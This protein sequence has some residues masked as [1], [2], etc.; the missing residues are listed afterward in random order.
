MIDT[1]P[2]IRRLLSAL[3]DDQRI[4]VE[5]E[6]STLR[7]RRGGPSRVVTVAVALL[8]AAAAAFL[9]V[10]AFG[11]RTAVQPGEQSP[12]GT[13]ALSR[14]LDES[15]VNDDFQSVVFL[16]KAD[17]T[18]LRPFLELPEPALGAEWSPDGS[19][20]AFVR[21]TELGTADLLA[22]L[23][24][25]SGELRLTEG[26]K[27]N[28]LDWSP[29]SEELLV[30]FGGENS[31][32]SVIGI[33]GGERVLLDEP[34]DY[35]DWSPDGRAIALS[36]VGDGDTPD[37]Y[38]ARAD[39]TGL[40]RIP[41]GNLLEQS[42]AWSPDGQRLAFWAFSDD[43]QDSDVYIVNADGTGLAR[44]TDWEGLD[45]MPVW[46]PDG[47]WIAFASDRDL[48]QEQRRENQRTGGRV[49]VSLYVMRADG[50]DVRK[51]VDGDDR[52]AVPTS[53]RP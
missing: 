39:G 49:G 45:A 21:T 10:R 17:G 50:S 34:F 19:E 42:V 44:L 43:F 2:R 25:G 32:V 31:G 6:L 4:D 28:D 36:G 33:N 53:W 14:L 3:V 22:V 41:T 27:V 9:L 1:D 13:I 30:T 15:E 12:S 38:I 40:E 11:Q 24:E 29:D 23:S 7:S 26:R 18:G 8:V 47:E 46:S 16:V 48:T 20:V 52:A 5:V 35:A 37:L 51:L